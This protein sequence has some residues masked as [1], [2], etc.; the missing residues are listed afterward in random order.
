MT[1][2]G[3]S[4]WYKLVILLQ[5]FSE[6]WYMRTTLIF[7][8]KHK[9]KQ[10]NIAPMCVS[11][12]VHFLKCHTKAQS[13]VCKSFHN[14]LDKDC[15]LNAPWSYHRTRCTRITVQSCSAVMTT[16]FCSKGLCTTWWTNKVTL[17]H[18]RHGQIKVWKSSGLQTRMTTLH[19]K[20]SS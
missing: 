11:C 19:S 20:N 16:L 12:A 14:I 13:Y 4:W 18:W 1:F 6:K 5:L 17:F 8:S 15:R 2:Q 7:K 10:S 3:F 9:N